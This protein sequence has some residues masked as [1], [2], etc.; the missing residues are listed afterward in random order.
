MSVELGVSI[1][2]GIGAYI[3]S[4]ISGSL[5]DEHFWLKIGF[6]IT[7]LFMLLIGLAAAMS[8]A[9]TI[10]SQLEGVVGVA[11]WLIGITIFLTFLYWVIYFLKHIL[12]Q[13]KL[14]KEGYYDD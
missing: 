11:Y 4:Y 10:S 8:F 5:D 14:K 13:A 12:E 9:A 2:L 3:L 7:S 1:M 6:N